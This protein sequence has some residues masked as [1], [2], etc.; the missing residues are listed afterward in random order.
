MKEH[1]F[2]ADIDF[3][4]L[5]DRSVEMKLDEYI[6]QDTMQTMVTQQD[7]DDDLKERS[8]QKTSKETDKGEESFD[9]TM[10]QEDC[11]QKAKEELK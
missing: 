1:P 4:I 9:F 8:S 2:F 7:E 6:R 3:D 11:I 5:D 10:L